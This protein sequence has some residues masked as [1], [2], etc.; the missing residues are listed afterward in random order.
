MRK[1]I[2]FIERRSTD[3]SVENVFRQIAKDVAGDEFEVEFQ[4]MPYGNDLVSIFKNLLFFRAKQADVYHLTGQIH[5]IALKLPPNKAVLTIHDV[6]FM[7]ERTGLRRWALK[8]L[9]LDWPMRRLRYVTA[10]SQ[11]TKDEIIRYTNCGRERIRVIE[12]PLIDGFSNGASREFNEICPTV[13]QVGSTGNKNIPNLLRAISGIRCRLV[14][15]GR[16]DQAI[17]DLIAE[18]GVEVEI[19]PDLNQSEIAVAYRESDIVA[20]CS[21]FEG[22]GLPIIE[23]QASGTLVVTSDLS[24][25]K[26]VAG[27][28][29]VLVDPNDPESIR[30]GIEKI[31]ADRSLRAELLEKGFANVRRFDPRKIGDTYRDLYSEMIRSSQADK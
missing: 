7:Y 25:M 22:F 23:G 3:H 15:V 17:K 26:E 12:N 13:L 30:A 10:I 19:K 5:Y 6:R 16:P 2:L 27:G 21:T 1:R 8:K 20:F 9:F 14:I 28:A 24:P 31:I 4:Q 18:S 11:K 29:A